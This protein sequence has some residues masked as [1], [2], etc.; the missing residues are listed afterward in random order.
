MKSHQRWLA[1]FGVFGAGLGIVAALKK[2]TPALPA[3]PPPTSDSDWAKVVPPPADAVWLRPASTS[4][5]SSLDARAFLDQRFARGED[6]PTS[7]QLAR[8]VAAFNQ[9]GVKND[10]KIYGRPSVETVN[11]ALDL[12]TELDMERAP[13]AVGKAVRDFS[14]E[15]YQTLP[16]ERHVA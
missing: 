4:S 14:I 11:A 10:G 7:G 1:L 2:K 15:A 5:A 16:L 9:L 3:K 13:P 6:K 8:I 12:A